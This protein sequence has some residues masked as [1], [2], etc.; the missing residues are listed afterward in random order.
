VVQAMGGRLDQ[1]HHDRR[2]PALNRRGLSP[3]VDSSVDG[4]RRY[5]P[6]NTNT[7]A[8][9]ARVKDKRWKSVGQTHPDKCFVRE[10]GTTSTASYV[11]NGRKRKI[12]KAQQRG[13]KLE[14]KGDGRVT[15]WLYRLPI[16]SPV[17][18]TQTAIRLLWVCYGIYEISACTFLSVGTLNS[19]IRCGFAASGNYERNTKKTKRARA[20]R[21]VADVLTC[22]CSSRSR[23]SPKRRM[24][25]CGSAGRDECNG[26]LIA[27]VIKSTDS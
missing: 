8:N 24:S 23:T 17:T 6:V 10:D 3:A 20:M 19:T 26:R 5:L 27:C 12:H 14:P 2:F 4:E 7:L 1:F 21:V 25:G 11:T 9:W 15:R 16:H 18:V 22:E 13:G